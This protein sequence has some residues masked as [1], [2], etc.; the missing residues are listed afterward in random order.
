VIERAALTKVIKRIKSAFLTKT[1]IPT[2][3]F[4]NAK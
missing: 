2:I 4:Y 1:F 3:V